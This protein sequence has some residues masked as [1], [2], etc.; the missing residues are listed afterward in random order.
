MLV[1]VSA[2]LGETSLIHIGNE[3]SF[4]TKQSFL[5]SSL[6]N[7]VHERRNQPGTFFVRDQSQMIF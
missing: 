3:P 5:K 2:L 1:S 6:I 4:A 7:F